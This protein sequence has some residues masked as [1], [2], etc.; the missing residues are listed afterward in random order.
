ML[1]LPVFWSWAGSEQW[2]YLRLKQLIAAR[3]TVDDSRETEP[4]PKKGETPFT[5]WFSTINIRILICAALIWVPLY[6]D[7]LP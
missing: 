1:S 7:A 3:N 6:L 5:V 4:K 2:V